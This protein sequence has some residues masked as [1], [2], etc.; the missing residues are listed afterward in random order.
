MSVRSILLPVTLAWNCSWSPGTARCPHTASSASINLS[1]RRVK[2]IICRNIPKASFSPFSPLT[3]TFLTVRSL[4][5]CFILTKSWNFPLIA[6]ICG[7]I[8]FSQ[9]WDKDLYS[10]LL[11]SVSLERKGISV[12]GL[13]GLLKDISINGEYIKGSPADR[14]LICFILC[15]N[16][17]ARR[18][19]TIKMVWLLSSN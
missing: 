11:T 3:A 15:L 7:M 9:H 5:W 17:T 1:G 2:Y 6:W 16:Q 4:R 12:E 13:E 10:N 14:K 18:D 8:S 19:K